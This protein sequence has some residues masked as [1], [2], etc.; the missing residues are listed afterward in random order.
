MAAEEVI[1]SCYMDDLMPTVATVEEAIEVRQQ[2]TELGD[3]ASLIP[4]S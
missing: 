1:K 4:H 2:L 3:R